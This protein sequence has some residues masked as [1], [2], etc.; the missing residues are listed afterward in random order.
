MVFSMPFA[1]EPMPD[2]ADEVRHFAFAIPLS[3][4][5]SA[6]IA[7]LRLVARGKESV[8]R[9]PSGAAMLDASGVHRPTRPLAS[10]VKASPSRTSIRW[11]ANAY[12][13][14]IVRD[15]VTGVILSLARGGQANV[16][17]ED[18]HDVD[19]VVSDGIHSV[20][21]SNGMN[22]AAPTPR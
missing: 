5:E 21:R 8:R 18:G 22:R 1:A 6:K 14:V 10:I 15:A 12:P 16:A 20:T 2:I 11:D 4:G 7:T 9:A 13:L 3:A 17:T 19:V